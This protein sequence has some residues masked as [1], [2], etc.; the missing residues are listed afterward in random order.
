MAPADGVVSC[1][2]LTAVP[3]WTLAWLGH[4][5]LW[6]LRG[7]LAERVLCPVCT[8]DL[9]P[10]WGM[11]TQLK[12]NSAA[13]SPSCT[14]LTGKEVTLDTCIDQYQ[15][16]PGFPELYS[17]IKVSFE[18]VTSC[19]RPLYV[20]TV[21]NCNAC[22]HLRA[23]SY[24]TCT[25]LQLKHIKAQFQGRFKQSNKYKNK[26]FTQPAIYPSSKSFSLWD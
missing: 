21:F 14:E 13:L 6:R 10:R 20:C 3:T 11:F 2:V 15:I 19:F 22:C 26:H 25:R 9:W 1:H 4:P 16:C 12:S 8:Q 7:P 5:S 17:C 18:E 23:L 24:P